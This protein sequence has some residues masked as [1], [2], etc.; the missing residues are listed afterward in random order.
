MQKYARVIEF[1]D[2]LKEPCWSGLSSIFAKDVGALKPLEGSNPS[3]SAFLI[4]TMFFLSPEKKIKDH[5]MSDLFQHF[6]GSVSDAVNILFYLA[7]N[8]R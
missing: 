5:T 6:F 2:I 4:F 1:Q 8:L 3:G 7:H